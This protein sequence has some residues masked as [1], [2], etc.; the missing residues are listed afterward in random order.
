[1]GSPIQPIQFSRIG[2]AWEICYVT[3]ALIVAPGGDT[4]T[5]DGARIC[6][7]KPDSAELAPLG[8]SDM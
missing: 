8:K 1:V 7:S 5:A 6:V 3:R 4:M 2:T